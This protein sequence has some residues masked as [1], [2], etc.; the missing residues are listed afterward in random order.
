VFDSGR[1]LALAAEFSPNVLFID[2]V[3]YEVPPLADDD[4]ELTTL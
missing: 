2:L 4:N 3:E 1:L